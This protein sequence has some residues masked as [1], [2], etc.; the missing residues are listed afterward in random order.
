MNRSSRPSWSKSKNSVPNFIGSRLGRRPARPP[1]PRPRT[2][3]G[4]AG[5]SRTASSARWRSWRPRPRTCPA[6]ISAA[7]IPIP[8]RGRPSAYASPAD[9]ADLL[10]PPPAAR[11][12][13]VVEEEVA[14]R[15][16]GHDQVRPAVAVRVADDHARAPCRPAARP[17]PARPLGHLHPGRRRHVLE[18]RRR[19]RCGRARTAA[20]RTAAA[21]RRPAPPPG[22][23][24][25]TPR[26]MAGDQVT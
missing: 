25:F 9:S 21:G 26:S 16:V 6:A 20:R 7:S 3:A 5:P 19:R 23:I 14:H 4:S 1:G 22:S 15:V 12:R 13:D 8:P 18:P 11:R 10:E 17:G 24:A 2:G